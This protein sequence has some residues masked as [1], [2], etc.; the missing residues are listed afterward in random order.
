MISLHSSQEKPASMPFMDA[1]KVDKVDKL[2]GANVSDAKVALGQ[3]LPS[4][5]GR[6]SEVSFA[7]ML[8]A[9]LTSSEV[10]ADKSS[11][12]NT[13]QAAFVSASAMDNTRVGPIST[14]LANT[15]GNFADGF[16]LHSK[17]PSEVMS[18]IHALKSGEIDGATPAL[19]SE[20]QGLEEAA[21][22]TWKGSEAFID[23]LNALLDKYLPA[24]EKTPEASLG[25]DFSE[26]SIDMT[27]NAM[28]ADQEELIDTA[29]QNRAQVL[30]GVEQ[31]LAQ[32]E[33]GFFNEERF[34]KGV[35]NRQEIESARNKLQA[36]VAAMDN[37]S[38]E[39]KTQLQQELL[40]L[41]EEEFPNTP[42][43]TEEWSELLK[44][45]LETRSEVTAGVVAISENNP[46]A[47]DQLVISSEE[48]AETVEYEESLMIATHNM[49]E[50]ARVNFTEALSS[51][52]LESQPELAG[53]TLSEDTQD[54]LNTLAVSGEVVKQESNLAEDAIQAVSVN[55]DLVDENPVSEELAAVAHAVQVES[56]K[57]VR[58]EMRAENRSET[59]IGASASVG[60]RTS[61]E[62]GQSAMQSNAN[63]QGREQPQAGNE[64]GNESRRDARENRNQDLP[65]GKEMVADSRVDARGENKE[66]VVN[67]TASNAQQLAQQLAQLMGQG[68]A[69]E[70][71]DKMPMSQMMQAQQKGLEQQA[72]LRAAE[73]SVS[74]SLNLDAEG[75]ALT[76]TGSTERRANLPLSL[77]SIPLPV[78][79][80][81]WGQAL[82]QRVV[83]MTNSHIQQA[84][85]TLNPE[86]LGPIQIKLHMDRD[87]QMQ[88][89]LNAQHGTTKEAMEAA[90]PRLREMLE[91]SGVQVASV[92]V[93]DFSQFADQ[94][95]EQDENNTSAFAAA[96]VS[97][98]ETTEL[99]SEVVAT[100]QSDQLVDYYA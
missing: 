36:N 14:H 67:K 13:V 84:Q 8:K 76:E 44:Q 48:L 39:E 85:I 21:E 46:F 45:N 72:S 98:D 30:E 91:Q 96:S 86:K 80:P 7:Q 50:D 9:K 93:G 60:T 17:M 10:V 34:A 69:Q 23:K 12:V 28:Q 15:A 31:K 95:T 41:V 33:Q 63:A 61:S 52:N 3:L 55:E 58:T 5:A 35:E 59:A 77:Q 19:L 64:Q 94:Q 66:P 6:D 32:R 87:Q 83:Y 100:T 27:I 4:F 42:Q 37:L 20:V 57:D 82:G 43:T 40:V 81:Q 68:K 99:A 1:V 11:L 71:S 22:E 29:Y 49:N 54:E 62:M 38:T 90:I 74:Q 97:G 47:N 2:A 75:L 26:A 53:Q 70:M 16:R 88:V 18:Q 89:T 73:A 51:V 56:R 24:D 78:K 79:H 25:A 92:D 65:A